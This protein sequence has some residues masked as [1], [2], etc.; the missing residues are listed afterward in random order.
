MIEK[1]VSGE[2]MAI[3]TIRRCTEYKLK[4]VRGEMYFILKFIREVLSSHLV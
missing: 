1:T 3:G 4:C 2:N